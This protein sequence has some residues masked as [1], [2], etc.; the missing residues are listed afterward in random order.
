MAID[1]TLVGPDPFDWEERFAELRKWVTEFTEWREWSE[2][3]SNR[4][5]PGWFGARS[6]RQRPDPPSWLDHECRQ[7]IESGSVL[8]QACD[9][10]AVWK[11]DRATAQIRQQR[12]A[13]VTE[14]EDPR[15]TKWWE[16]V[17]FDLLWPMTQLR[18]SA[19][20]VVGMHATINVTQ[21][22]QIFV[23]PGAMLM[24]LP[25]S[26]G[27]RAWTPAADWGFSYRLV[28][29]RFPGSIRQ[30]SLHLNVATAWV[31]AG[32]EGLGRTSIDLAGFSITFAR[33]PTPAQ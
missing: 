18:V 15:K 27:T 25:T 29:F 1:L 33:N 16:H 21:R 10:L 9:L 12:V 14:R 11:D 26:R 19:Y 6:R 28:D 4:R 8:Q 31:F 30:A 5:E 32:P 20:G 2:R 13:T 17:H 24:N 7:A 3:W 22:F 23:A